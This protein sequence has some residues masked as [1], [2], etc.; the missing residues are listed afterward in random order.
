M[1]LKV[2]S[3]EMT[4]L[5]YVEYGEEAKQESGICR[6]NRGR[7]H[8]IHISSPPSFQVSRFACSETSISAMGLRLRRQYSTVLVGTVANATSHSG[9]VHQTPRKR[10]PFRYLPAP[11]NDNDNDN[12]TE[13]TAHRFTCTRQQLCHPCFC[14]ALEVCLLSNR[15]DRQVF[16]CEGEGREGLRSLAG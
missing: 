13:T 16:C 9:A 5:L 8:E 14:T 4:V 2:I 10:H 3:R 6:S 12:H 11:I 15:R 1:D 7:D